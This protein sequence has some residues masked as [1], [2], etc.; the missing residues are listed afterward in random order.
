EGLGLNHFIEKNLSNETVMAAL[1]Q[2]WL[3][4]LDDLQAVNVAHGDLQHGN[5]LVTADGSLRL[6]D[7]DGMWVPKLKG[8]KSNEIG[9]P[10]YQSPLRSEKDFHPDIDSFAG[11]VIHV[12]IRALAA[13]PK[14]WAKHN[15]GDNLLFRRQDFVD[16][17]NS[18]VFADVQAVGDDEI[19]EKV[20]DLIRACG[21]KPKRSRASRFFKP[22]K[23]EPARKAE[24]STE[25]PK[26]PPAAPAAAPPPAPARPQAP[27]PLAGGLAPSPRGRVIKPA[28]KARPAPPP[29][30]APAP[31]P[32]P[33]PAPAPAPAPKGAGTWLDDHVRASGAA[34]AK[35]KRS[36]APGAKA[37]R[38]TMSDPRPPLG[39]RVLGFTRL[40]IHF[41]LLGPVTIS[42]IMQLRELQEGFGDR[43]TAI[44]A[45][46]FGFALLLGILSLA[47]LYVGRRAHRVVSMLFFGLTAVIMLLNIFSELLTAGWSEWTGDDPVQCAVM[48]SML[49]LSGLGLTVEH[50]CHRLGVVTRWR[51]P[52]DR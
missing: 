40:L 20:E 34:P 52:W 21:V 15:N 48:L 50:F 7:Y 13:Q 42:S 33:R 31:A 27:K 6:I 22:K 49:V 12:A 25:A 45:S 36:A 51:P 30:A 35:A 9:H 39:K 10:D 38:K 46:G 26:A 44:L 14:L 18:Q 16:P 41:L 43:A 32:K 5:V 8:Q 28:P 37:V 11:D 29:K 24:T 17:R 19:R 1:E 2:D 3:A 47:T 23:A 4:L